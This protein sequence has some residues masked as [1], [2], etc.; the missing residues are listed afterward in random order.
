MESVTAA[1]YRLKEAIF[2]LGP[3]GY[4]FEQLCG[5]IFQ[6]LGYIVEIGVEV[7]GSC[8]HHEMDVI[9]TKDHEQWLCECKYTHDKGKTI[10]IQVPLYVHSRVEDI[11]KWRAKQPNFSGFEFIPCIIT[12]NRFSDYCLKY[13]QCVGMKVISWNFPTENSLKEL[14]EQFRLFPITVLLSLSFQQKQWLVERGVVCCIQLMENPE[15]LDSMGLSLRR[16]KK[17]LEEIENICR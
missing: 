10:G 6:S 11:T 7:Q 4:P 13:A 2:G 16:K 12:N 5:R 9:A 3:T 15:T 1:K 17:I 8:I 14:I